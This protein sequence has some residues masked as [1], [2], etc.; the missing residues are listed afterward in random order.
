[1]KYGKTTTPGAK[2]IPQAKMGKAKTVAGNK[3]ERGSAMNAS[4]LSHGHSTAP[5][6]RTS[7]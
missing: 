2:S 7:C 4:H 3:G 5:G 1:M 6:K